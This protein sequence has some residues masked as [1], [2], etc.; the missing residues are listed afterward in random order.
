MTLLGE[1]HRAVAE[2]QLTLHYQPQLD[3]R[4]GRVC[5]VEALVRWRHPSRGL[6]QPDR[7]LALA[8]QFNLMPAV[9]AFVL[10]QALTDLAGLH[11]A[12]H[13][14]RVS[15]NVSAA[16]LIDASL[17]QLVEMCLAAAGMTADSLVVEVT[18][19]TVMA[20]RVRALEVLHRLRESGVH[21]SVDDYGTGQSSLS[22]LRDLPISEIKLDR[23]FLVGVPA[24]THNAAIVRSTIEL[25]HALDLPIVTEGVEESEALDWLREVGCD[26]AQGY[27]IARPLP[28]EDLLGWLAVTE[29]LP[30]PRGAGAAGL[31]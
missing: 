19:D 8:E 15:V 24:D 2:K 9:T 21:V 1:L 3:L 26:L 5:G 23:A 4:T 27:H 6:V 29:S 7:F 11:A 13:R 12:G 17:P 22:Y 25:A 31:G 20:D 16:D 30:A 14:L 28:L 18:E 10:G